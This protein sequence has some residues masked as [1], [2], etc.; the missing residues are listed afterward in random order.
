MSFSN[1]YVSK[2]AFLYTLLQV[3]LYLCYMFIPYTRVYSLVTKQHYRMKF[4]FKT[5]LDEN[6]LSTFLSYDTTVANPWKTLLLY[7]SWGDFSR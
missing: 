6:Y 7:M 1:F 4:S 3:S 2:V 5:L